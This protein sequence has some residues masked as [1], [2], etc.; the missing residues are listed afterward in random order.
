VQNEIRDMHWYSF[1]ITILVHITYRINH[2][3]DPIHLESKI[4]KKVHYY[5]LDEKEH[6]TL[7]VQYAFVLN[8][9]FLQDMGCLLDCHV[10]WSDGCS[11]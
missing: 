1:Q 9:K 2:G 6:D 5:I 3:Y 10:V 8:W 4:L 11:N 7:F